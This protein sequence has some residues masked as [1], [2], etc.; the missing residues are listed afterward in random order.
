MRA[1]AVALL[2]CTLAS[3]ARGQDEA[4]PL[5]LGM[6][7]PT[8]LAAGVPL[9]F[10]P[11]PEHDMPLD[12]LT[13]SEGPHHVEIATA[14]PWL[15]PEVAKL[16]YDTISFRVVSL[17]DYWVEVIVHD[18]DIRWPSKTM[19]LIR[20]AV[21]V[22]PW[23]VYLLDVYS[24]ETPE[25]ALIYAGAEASGGTVGQTEAGRPL[26]V[27]ETRHAWARVAYADATEAEA[28]P[29]G[30]VRWHDGERLLV[31]ISLLS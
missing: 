14:P 13:V 22:Q 15:D 31:R 23:A 24:I 26:Q 10:Y 11:S 9:F 1:L 2:A 8:D 12:S 17:R 27:L 16:D 19:W 25:A 28:G 30:W 21:E 18:R 3:G 29:L 7:V 5:G 20:D 4:L 6:A